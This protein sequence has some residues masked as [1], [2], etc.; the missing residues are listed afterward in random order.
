M[1]E[2]LSVEVMTFDKMI[3]Q[4]LTVKIMLIVLY[5]CCCCYIGDPTYARGQPVTF[6]IMTVRVI[7]INF[8]S[9]IFII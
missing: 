4:V 2:L 6:D 8:Y 1:H 3:G 7:T 9:F 5:T